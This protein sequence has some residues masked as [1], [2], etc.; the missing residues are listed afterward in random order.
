[1]SRNYYDI[2]GVSKDA[3]QEEIKKAYRK[4]ALKYHP[5]KNQGDQK[6][7]D[8]FKQVSEAYEVLSDEKKRKIYDQY[9]EEGIKAQSG[10][11]GGAGFSSMEE[12]L[13]TF[14]GA[15]GGGSSIFDNFFGQEGPGAHYAQQGANKKISVTVTFEEAAKGAQ[16]EAII[17]T[18]VNCSDCGGSGAFSPSDIK[19]C[20]TCKGA[21]QLHQSRG[22][23]S[24][25][26]TCPHC[27]GSGTVISKACG[28][29]HGAGKIKKKQNVK[30]TIPA[31][32]DNGMRIKM[33]G[34]GDAG[35]NGGPPGDLY[36]Y[37]TVTGHEVFKREG[38]DLILELPI[39][40]TE[41]A[42]GCKKDIPTLDTASY[43]LTIPEGT[44][45]GKILRVRSLGFPNVHGNTK[46]DMLIHVK[47]ETPIN[48]SAEQKRILQEFSD[49]EKPQNSPQAKGFFDKLKSFF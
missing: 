32:I 33:S 2:L 28:G 35:E 9:G 44:Q 49:S 24:M 41:A 39:S 19:T 7:S 12:A 27:H 46:G 45:S 20:S 3:S 8:T 5:D 18:L 15:F 47:V 1:M 11:G 36:V 31:G 17:S 34:Y 22:F 30:I 40:F 42:L 6:A 37:I 23:F 48:L 43:R 16:K 10:A 21:G 38:D 25:S 29:C 14:M 13:R 4:L 26:T